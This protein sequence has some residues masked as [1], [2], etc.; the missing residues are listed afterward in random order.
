MTNF[1]I[2]E[3]FHAAWDFSKM[4]SAR[5]ILPDKSFRPA[6]MSPKNTSFSAAFDIGLDLAKNTSRS[7][8]LRE[9]SHGSMPYRQ[10][11]P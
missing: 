8:F 7:A 5:H 1:L 9:M 6:S 3:S 10:R 11:L 4:A 2:N